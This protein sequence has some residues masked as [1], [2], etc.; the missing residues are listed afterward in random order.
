ML[1][2]IGNKVDF[3]YLADYVPQSQAPQEREQQKVKENL[4]SCDPQ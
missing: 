1:N 3:L 4:W 2:L